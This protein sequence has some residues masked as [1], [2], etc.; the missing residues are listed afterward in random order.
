V[1]I[2]V[3]KGRA[4]PAQANFGAAGSDDTQKLVITRTSVLPMAKD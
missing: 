2:P 3:C 1:R 4:T